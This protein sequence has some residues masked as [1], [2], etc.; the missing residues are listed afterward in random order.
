MDIKIPDKW[1][2]E[3][4]ETN[5]KPDDIARCLS[6]CGPSVEK[7]DETKHGIVYNI[8]VTGNRIDSASVYGIAREAAVILPRF[9]YKAKLKPLPKI[10][11]KTSKK[12][13]YL[14]T[15]VNSRLC[16][17]FSMILIKD[18]KI[19]DSPPDMVEMIS[20]CGG[21]GINNVVDISNY[22]MF[23]YGQPLHTFDY[24][25]IK[26]SL[27]MLRESKKGESIF[28][29]DGV[30]RTLPGGDMVIEDGSGKL[31]DLCGIMGGKL[32]AVDKNT[33]NV[34]IYVQ[35]YNPSYVRRTSMSLAHRTDASVLF[36]KGLNPES[37]TLTIQESIRLFE[38]FTGGKADPSILDVYPNPWKAKS[39][40]LRFDKV[41]K[42]LGIDIEERQIK[43][44]LESLGF[45]ISGSNPM[46][47]KIPS[48]RDND[49]SIEEDLIEEIAR[50]YG[51]HNI[52]S[53][54]MHTAIPTENRNGIFA[55]E[56][57]VKDIIKGYGG[58]E[59][60]TLTLVSE[61]DVVGK[62]Y[63]LKNPLGKDAEYLRTSM[64][65]SLM[66]AKKENR[67]INDEYH[68]FE[69]SNI[70]LPV[71]SELP[72]E[73]SVLAGI[74]ENSEYRHAKGIIEALLTE[75]N[76]SYEFIEEEMPLFAPGMG[77]KIMCGKEKL[78]IFGITEQGDFYYEFDTKTLFNNYSLV[79]KYSPNSKFP[80]QIEDITFTLPEKTRIGDVI[81]QISQRAKEIVSVVLKEVYENSFTFRVE[82]QSM[83]KTLENKDVEKIRSNIIS[84]IEKKFGGKVK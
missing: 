68:L 12:V 8:E 45:S 23:E 71:E 14:T 73:K 28:T 58:I 57:Y 18:V 56:N 64:L 1:L 7:V 42:V 30:K 36:E 31:I 41:Q 13:D 50:I 60:Y 82:Y 16:P 66:L 75:L 51:Y 11:I 9:G 20:A 59:V 40:R 33:K 67:N 34:L 43:S 38:K 49:I 81:T 15:I 80:S 22:L 74:I 19:S 55:F 84:A 53:Q 69:I 77:L 32:S 37:V 44:I 46:D 39:I 72:Q 26:D 83:E 79:G 27:M 78:G 17:R 10:K 4:L 62:A 48:Y 35:S 70:Y 2:R 76:I 21:R 29:L 63:K 65:P 54:L 5:A 6:L 3:H 52:S 25:K 24:D 47:V 61:K